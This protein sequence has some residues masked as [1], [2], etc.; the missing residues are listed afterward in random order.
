MSEEMQAGGKEIKRNRTCECLLYVRTYAHT[1]VARGVKRCRLKIHFFLSPFE[2]KRFV[3]ESHLPAKG[4][5]SF[6][7]SLFLFCEKGE[8]SFF[9]FFPFVV[10]YPPPLFFTLLSFF[11]EILSFS[12]WACLGHHKWEEACSHV[13]VYVQYAEKASQ[14]PTGCG[15][16]HEYKAKGS[17][18]LF[19]DAFV[20][21]GPNFVLLPLYITYINSTKVRSHVPIRS[22]MVF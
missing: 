11:F 6:S 12:M 2:R 16:W 4:F 15:R 20:S 5:F 17:S 19:N 13:L 18:S 1:V 22:S 7:S 9:L 21:R 14:K 3:K 10:L 8:S